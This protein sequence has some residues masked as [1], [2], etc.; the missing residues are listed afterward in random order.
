MCS[1][2]ECGLRNPEPC[3]L[4][5]R[6]V[7]RLN[8]AARILP[9]LA[10]IALGSNIEP[11]HYLPRAVR[12]LGELGRLIACSNTYQNPAI[13]DD[14]QPD[15][16]NAAVLIET[17]LSPLEIRRKLREIETRL[18]RLRT[19]DKFAPRTID[20]DLCIYG[21]LQL[22]DPALTLPDPDVLTRPFLALTL[23]EL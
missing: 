10:F 20:L 15:Y 18:D 16:L 17:R 9:E 12:A 23:A 2:P 1:V 19:A 13:A 22:N 11:E 7:W 3:V 4:H 8:G 21:D 6:W 14:A 5:A